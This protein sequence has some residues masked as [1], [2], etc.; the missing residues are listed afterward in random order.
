VFDQDRDVQ[1]AIPRR[2]DPHIDALGFHRPTGRTSW[3]WRKPSSITWIE[4]N[5]ADLVEEDRLAVGD[6]W[7]AHY[8]LR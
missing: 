3:L 1:V 8:E 2:D 6:D 7:Q 5:V 4:P